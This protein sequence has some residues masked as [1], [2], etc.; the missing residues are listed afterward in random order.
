MIDDLLAFLKSRI[1]EDYQRAVGD[2]DP[3]RAK[4]EIEAKQRII[5]EHPVLT[6]W[7]VCI[8]CS[9]FKSGQL[10]GKVLGP[11]PTIRWLAYPYNDHPDYREAWRP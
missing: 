4:R 9:D 11:C 6:A 5:E 3:F 8:R 2:D 10:L 7:R 1:D